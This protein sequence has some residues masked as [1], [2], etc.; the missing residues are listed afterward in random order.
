[1]WEA[2]DED[3]EAELARYHSVLHLQTPT[4]NNYNH[5]NPLRIED[6]T[7]AAELDARIVEAWAGHPRREMIANAVNFL[8]KA[9]RAVTKLRLELPACCTPPSLR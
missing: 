5:S 1:M 2:L 3:R 9:E 6:A 8:D 4:S 7:Q